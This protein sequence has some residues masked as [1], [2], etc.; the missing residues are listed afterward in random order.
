MTMLTTL[1][2]IKTRL[3]LQESDVVD[4]DLLTQFLEMTSARLENACNRKFG[5]VVGQVDEFEGDE[6]ELRVLRFPIDETGTITFTRTV[7]AAE[8]PLDVT[9]QINWV[10]RRGCVIS[11]VSVV[12]RWKEV[13]K[14]TYSGGYLLPGTTAL[15]GTNPPALPDDVSGAC[16]EQVVYLFQ[17]KDRL[18]VTGMSS[19]Q[20]S[21]QQLSKL[22]LLPSVQAVVDKYERWMP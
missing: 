5:Y 12:G 1:A 3:K 22:D 11:L 6:T 10:V 14:V 18:G 15:D 19:G 9:D 8:G 16:I 13:L 20:G 21:F 4:D 2:D 17:N 7:T